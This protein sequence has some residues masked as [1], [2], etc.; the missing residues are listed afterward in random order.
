MKTPLYIN[1][2]KPGPI[3]FYQEHKFRTHVFSSKR[4]QGF[5]N[6][7]ISMI[8]KINLFVI[9]GKPLGNSRGNPGNPLGS[10]YPMQYKVSRCVTDFKIRE[11]LSRGKPCNPGKAENTQWKIS[12]CLISPFLGLMSGE[13][14][15]CL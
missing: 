11:I 4:L 13:K 5:P 9:I 15:D 10:L 14:I 2:I 6:Y 3:F 1:S 8:F 12:H 7:S